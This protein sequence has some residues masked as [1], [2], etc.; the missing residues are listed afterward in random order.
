MAPEHPFPAGFNECYD[1][2]KWAY[3][4][5]EELQIDKEN[6]VI[7]G[8]SAGGNFAATIA[9]M[10]NQSKEFTVKAQIMDYAIL[11]IAT[12]PADKVTE[13]D[14]ISAERARNFNQLYLENEKDAF[15]PF[16]SPV[17]ATPEMLAGLPPALI[18]TAGQECLCFEAERY[19]MMLVEAGVRVTVK[20]FLNSAHG[21]TIN[22]NA[23][24]E[25]ADELM[26]V[27]LIQTFNS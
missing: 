22:C 21:F 18:I 24:F 23:E 2:V 9:L 16:V 27:T 15:N 5:A 4:H 19:A 25:E 3:E 17:L 1:V 10:A 8:H 20:R 7:G 13:T 12:D 6:V 11:D 26:I 14:V